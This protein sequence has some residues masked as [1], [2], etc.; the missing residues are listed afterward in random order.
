MGKM[1]RGKVPMGKK[2]GWVKLRSLKWHCLKRNWVRCYATPK[3]MSP[4]CGF[5][6][7]E[8][9][10]RTYITEIPCLKFHCCAKSSRL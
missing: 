9:F 7:S 5:V 10:T 6:G 8:S 4:E 1:A 3:M 2:T